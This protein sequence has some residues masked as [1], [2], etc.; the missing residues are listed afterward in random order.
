MKICKLFVLVLA[1]MI[2]TNTNAQQTDPNAKARKA[3]TGKSRNKSALSNVNLSRFSVTGG[4][5]TA[6]YL[7]DLIDGNKPFAQSNISFT[8]GLVYEIYPKLNAR[9]NMGYQ[10][11]QG[12][13]S[14]SSG[15]HKSRNLSFYSNVFD[16]FVSLEYSLLD[17]KTYKLTP[18]VSAGF[19]MFFFDPYAVSTAGTKQKLR[20]LGTEGQGFA[21][22]PTLYNKSDIEVPLGIGVKYAL[23]KRVKL[24]LEFNYRITGTD[25]LDDVSM[26]R[27]A[28]KA[29]LDLKNPL[30]A[31]FAYRGN[32]VGAGPYPAKYNRLPRGNPEKKDVFYTTQIQVAY[33]L[34][35]SGTVKKGKKEVDL[36]TLGKADDRDGDGIADIFD[37]CPDEPGLKYL[38][39]CPDRDND[40]VADIDDKCPD[41]AGF[42][43]YQG[44]LIPD[45]DADGV[46]DE[47][48]KCPDVPGLARYQGCAAVD[49]DG[50]GINDDDDKCVTEKGI[51]S[52]F[53]CPA[54]SPVL[55]DQVNMAAKNIFFKTG[56]AELLSRSFINL[57]EVVKILKENPTYKIQIN[58]YTDNRGD[59]LMNQNLSSARAASV[60]DYI[61]NKGIDES[62]LF[63]TGYGELNPIATNATVAGQTQNRRVEMQLRNY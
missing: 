53:G 4:I 59:V 38:Q 47:M 24:Q 5:G 28:D 61:K 11:V 50:D 30:T 15:A 9:L 20:D 19:G 51:A 41:I 60:R 54:I 33:K 1:L 27:Y 3:S 52:N 46:N 13:D 35:S 63:S 29:M 32:E 49:T 56:S 55:I 48:D 18:Y 44:C 58:G 26:N 7:G 39:G 31:K 12:A 45:S 62:R 8:G 16:V 40:G 43:R 22:F 42:T 21:G 17:M 36:P 6:N 2:S 37:R 14:K 34:N 23:S 10:K 25:Y 57:L